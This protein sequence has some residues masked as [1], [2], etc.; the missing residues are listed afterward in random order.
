MRKFQVVLV[1]VF[2]FLCW[3][4]GPAITFNEPQPAGVSSLSS[5]PEKM[6]GDYLSEDGESTVS[7]SDKCMLRIYDY[8]VANHKDSIEGGWHIGHDTLFAGKNSDSV[9]ATNV[10]LKGD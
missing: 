2:I 10:S 4:C 6:K 8:Q 5:F 7:I 1:F 9:L 3:G